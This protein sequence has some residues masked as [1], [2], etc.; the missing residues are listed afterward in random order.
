[1]LIQI[2]QTET[3][4]ALTA[5]GWE[6]RFTADPQRAQE[7]MELYRQ[8]GYEVHAEPASAAHRTDECHACHAGM[9]LH[10]KTIYTRK[11]RA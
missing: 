11:R 5:D 2:A 4:R 9:A 1:M 10:W 7:V 8:L 3:D 6:R